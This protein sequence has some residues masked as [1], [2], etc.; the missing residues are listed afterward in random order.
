MKFEN[1]PNL[2]IEVDVTLGWWRK[3][4]KDFPQEVYSLYEKSLNNKEVSLTDLGISGS[5]LVVA[6]K[7]DYETSIRKALF[8]LKRVR[9]VEK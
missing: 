4:T 8:N 5:F 3:K 1:K 7:L 6:H 2:S 9:E